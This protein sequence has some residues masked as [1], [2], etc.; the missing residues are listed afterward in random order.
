MQKNIVS[1]TE[2]ENTTARYLPHCNNIHVA[3]FILTEM[4]V[5]PT[6]VAYKVLL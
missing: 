3:N 4:N 5:E 6:F 1:A 2:V